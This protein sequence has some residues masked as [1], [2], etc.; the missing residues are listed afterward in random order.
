MNAKKAKAL[1]RDARRYGAEASD[2]TTVSLRNGQTINSPYSQRGLYRRLK[3]EVRGI[4]PSG[5]DI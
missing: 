5:K 4:R 3:Q 2:V 1:R